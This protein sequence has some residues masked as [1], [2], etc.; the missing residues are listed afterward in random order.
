MF[1]FSITRAA[2][3][4]CHQAIVWA[5]VPLAVLNGRTLVACGC[6]GQFSS[7][8]HCQATA[9]NESVGAS[10]HALCP[11]CA[12]GKPANSTIASA[13]CCSSHD[14]ESQDDGNRTVRGHH[15]RS[16]AYFEV[17]P[18]TT[19]SSI[20]ADDL[21]ATAVFADS[22][23]LPLTFDWQRH[24]LALRPEAHPPD[25]LVVVLHRLVI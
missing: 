25:D 22:L 6:T 11:K 17:T 19:A 16:L 18:G 9:K 7:V 8:C 14:R 10:E 21:A 2:R 13:N 23:V 5:M 4:R 1:G 12:K 3:R 20:A 15:C 24:T